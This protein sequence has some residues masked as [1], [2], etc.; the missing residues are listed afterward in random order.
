VLSEV[1]SNEPVVG[2]SDVLSIAISLI[3]VII[4]PLE[5]PVLPRVTVP[6]APNSKALSLAEAVPVTEYWDVELGLALYVSKDSSHY[7]LLY[8]LC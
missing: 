5:A 2:K 7:I 4:S 3:I 8:H 1:I 6:P